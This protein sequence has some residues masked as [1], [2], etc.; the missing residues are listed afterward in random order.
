MSAAGDF[1]AGI[2]E[3]YYG[4][5]WDHSVRM[6]I[7]SLLVGM[8]LSTFL[9][10]PKADHY[11]R[12]R[13]QSDWPEREWRRL[14]QLATHARATG[15]TFGVGLS[16]YAL[17]DNYGAEERAVLKGKVERLNALGAPLLALLFDDMPGEIDDLASRQAE[18]VAD[19][20]SWTESERLVVCPTYYSDDPVLEKHFGKR[21]AGYWEQLGAQLAPEVD[22]FWTGPEVCSGT[23]TAQD[24]APVVEQLQRPLV[25]WDNY[26]VNDGAVRSRHLY[27]DPLHGRDSAIREHLAGHLC[28]PM[29]QAWLSLPA[30][31]GL[32]ALYGNNPDDR[33]L[34]GVLGDSTL[35]LIQRDASRFL[36]LGLDGIDA[37]EREQLVSEYSEAGTPAAAEVV[38]WLSGDYTFDPACLTD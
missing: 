23:I 26:P 21:P 35:A 32:A 38:A 22:L 14:Q 18:I 20:L 17:Y 9:Y 34:A 11:L 37:R 19:L 3:G 30:L 31:C 5:A 24:L 4:K 29:N 2:V 7:V 36:D 27:L 10:C 8:G 15:V 16:P 13:W 12:R 6:Q 33:W 1:L 25:L 28:N